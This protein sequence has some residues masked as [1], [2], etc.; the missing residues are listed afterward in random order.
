[1]QSQTVKTVEYHGIRP[2]D[3][4]GQVGLRNPERG[5]RTEA[6]IADDGCWMHDIPSES[7]R[8]TLAPAFGDDYWLQDALQYAPFGLT[9]VQAYCYLTASIACPLPDS[10]LAALADSLAAMRRHGLKALLRFA[11]ETDDSRLAGPTLATIMGHLDQLAP[12]IQ[13]HLDVIYVL[14]A[15]FVGAWGEWHSS[16]HQLEDDPAALAAIIGR[17]LAILPPERCTQV[18]VPK[19]KRWVLGTPLLD[20]YKL[21]TAGD[22]HSGRPLARIGYH[23]DGFLAGHNDG[24]TWPEPPLFSQPGNPEFDQMTAESLYVPVDAELFWRD[25]AGP[26]GGLA[27]MQRLWLHHN[28][29]LSLAHS[30]SGREGKPYSI[31]RWMCEPLTRM[32]AEAGGLPY[33]DGYFADAYGDEAERTV[34]AYITDHLGYRFE[35]QRAVLPARLSADA[36]LHCRVELVNRGCSGPVN[37]RPVCWVLRGADGRRHLFPVDADPRR[38]YPHAPGDRSRQPL[39]HSIMLDALLPSGIAPG[40]CQLAL[41]LPDAAPSLCDDPRYAIRF[42]NRDTL[43]SEGLN[44]LGTVEIVGKE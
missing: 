43:W 28:D 1:M 38:W 5:W 12:V 19:F 27:A 18:R 34:F 11:Y 22:A 33:A 32:R 4:W 13:Q 15:G 16:C 10:K 31:D 2:T 3:P 23:N 36:R 6:V 29:T 25:F 42:A 21:L 30:Y 41:W 44:V 24:Y 37:P 14:Q 35:L 7:L 8:G 17:L 26:V 40:P 9:V 39:T 20:E